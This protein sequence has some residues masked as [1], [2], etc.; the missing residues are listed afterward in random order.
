[1]IIREIY[2]GEDDSE[3]CPLIRL[4]PSPQG[5]DC[6][7]NGEHNDIAK[8]VRCDECSYYLYCFP[9]Y[10]NYPVRHEY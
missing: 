8:E 10:D 7:G 6:L 1:M 3:D 2:D 4:T 5:K 9:Q